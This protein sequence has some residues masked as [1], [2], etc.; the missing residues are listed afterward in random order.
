MN[1]DNFSELIKD[2]NDPHSNNRLVIWIIFIL[3]AISTLFIYYCIIERFVGPVFSWMDIYNQQHLSN[4]LL[5]STGPTHIAALL[6]FF[7]VNA[8]A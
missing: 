3:L 4:C 1:K 6:D 2:E 5:N 7:F 8:P